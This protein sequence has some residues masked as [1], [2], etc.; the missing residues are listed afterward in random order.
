MNTVTARKIGNLTSLRS[1]VAASAMKFIRAKALIRHS[2]ITSF[3]LTTMVCANPLLADDHDEDE[4]NPF[5]DASIYFELNDTDGDL[6]IHAL[7][8]S[9][10]LK[11]LRI[12]DPF[13]RSLL[14]VR[15]NGRLRQQGLTKFNFESAESDFEKM[16][17]KELFS[18]FPDGE[19]KVAGLT[20]ADE[21]IETELYLS[22]V[23]PE[24]VPGLTVNG[25]AMVQDCDEDEVPTVTPPLVISWSAVTQSHSELGKTGAIEVDKYQVVAEVEEPQL[26]VYSVDVPFYVTSM[27]IPIE[28]TDLAYGEPLEYEVLVRAHNGNQTTIESCIIVKTSE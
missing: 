6:G 27:K 20:L 28:F 16:P 17:P 7:L 24:P 15:M 25:T 5:D 22:H 26:N 3:A 13:E 2:L 14:E 12:Q 10:P 23:M 21:E 19:Y 11:G 8:D 18:R 9:D 4:E 1:F